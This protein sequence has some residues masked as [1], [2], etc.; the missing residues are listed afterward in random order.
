MDGGEREKEE[1][2]YD[3]SFAT[4]V[5]DFGSFLKMRSFSKKQYLFPPTIASTSAFRSPHSFTTPLPHLTNPPQKP[6]PPSPFSQRPHSP[7]HTNKPRTPKPKTSKLT[8]QNKPH[9]HSPAPPPP[10]P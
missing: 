8:P 5:A 7:L 1:R 2:T 9:S 10:R 6:P 4:R 3:V